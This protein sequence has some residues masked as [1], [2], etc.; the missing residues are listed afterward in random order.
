MV[1]W[2]HIFFIRYGMRT[3]FLLEYIC[4]SKG[5]QIEGFF[6]MMDS[7]FVIPI[8]NLLDGWRS[9]V[10]MIF[11][12]CMNADTDDLSR[13]KLR[14]CNETAGFATTIQWMID[15]YL[16]ETERHSKDCH[17]NNTVAHINDVRP[18]RFARH[19]YDSVKHT[20]YRPQECQLRHRPETSVTGQI[21][22]YRPK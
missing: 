10:V 19:C 13:W 12:E 17:A 7:V 9:F 21:Y 14:C 22:I 1:Q 15:T 5:R 20:L 8:L 11:T 3:G 6:Q 16:L 4:L 2:R 18:V